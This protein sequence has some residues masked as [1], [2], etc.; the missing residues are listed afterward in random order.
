VTGIVAAIAAVALTLAGRHFIA[1][2][3]DVMAGGFEGSRVGLAPLA[4]LFGEES[5][6][7]VTR[8]VV[9]AF[10]GLMFGIGLAGGLTH[11]PAHR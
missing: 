9:S 2:S 5:L 10:E 1:A 7:P 8:T 4:H 3:L 6:R 11:R